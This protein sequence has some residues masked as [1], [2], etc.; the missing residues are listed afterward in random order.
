MHLVRH[1]PAVALPV[2][3]TRHSPQR[4]PTRGHRRRHRRVD[5]G[6][7]VVVVVVWECG[8]GSVVVGM[9]VVV[10]V[11]RAWEP[12]CVCL[13]SRGQNRAKVTIGTVYLVSKCGQMAQWLSVSSLLTCTG[14]IPGC[15]YFFWA[16]AGTQYNQN[17]IFQK[18]IISIL[19]VR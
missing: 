14:S 2:D 8:G 11:D 7:V 5:V 4:R 3:P 12:F 10:V 13:K 18:P 16:S 9:V 19:I 17:I 1:P 6:V 15:T